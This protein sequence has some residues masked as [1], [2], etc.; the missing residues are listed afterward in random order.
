[1][2]MNRYWPRHGSLPMANDWWNVGFYI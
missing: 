1:M 2:T